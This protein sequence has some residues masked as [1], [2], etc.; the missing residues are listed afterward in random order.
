MKID[1]PIGNT[2]IVEI[3]K[4]DIRKGNL[5]VPDLGKDKCQIGKV[6]AVGPGF[7]TLMGSLIPTTVKVGDIVVVPK[8]GFQT[9]ELEDKEY[10]TGKEND[11]ITTLKNNE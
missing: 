5:M 6:I 7:Y 3:I 1:Q 8:L 2:V 4:K 10:L 11:L 9:L